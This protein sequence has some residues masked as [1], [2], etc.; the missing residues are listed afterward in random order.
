MKVFYP[1]QH[2]NISHIA[3]PGYRYER[4][5]EKVWFS[6]TQ[7][8]SLQ[9]IDGSKIGIIHLGKKNWNEG[10]DAKGA[11]ILVNGRIMEGDVEFHLKAEDWFHHGHHENSNYKNVILHVLGEDSREAS[12]LP[13]LTIVLDEK[14]PFLD[15]CTLTDAVENPEEI[16]K[17]FA[18]FRWSGLVDSFYRKRQTGKH[19]KQIL[20]KHGFS[21]LGKGGNETIF[22]TLA[23]RIQISD[24]GD[25]DE[26]EFSQLPW[27][28]LGMRPSQRPFSRMKLA[29][30]F[31]GFISGWNENYHF[32]TVLFQRDVE[33]KLTG[34]FGKGICTELILNVLYPGMASESAASGRLESMR[35]WE[36]KWMALT[37]PY[38]YSRY[39]RR[40]S[41]VVS[42]KQ[43]RSVPVLQGLK[44]MDLEFC[45]PRHCTVCPLKKHGSLDTN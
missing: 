2:F 10:P 18:K 7:G 34:R 37:L 32:N 5:L 40:F 1:L 30:E 19:W 17:Q 12:S 11:R 15:E 42:P 43:L 44:Q 27:K 6:L 38:S 29:K 28:V 9:S 14:L 20:M 24:D 36:R 26:R 3:E 4:D 25:F 39:Q 16:L 45:K 8:I 31:A 13:G 33:E 23:D 35:Y 21:I 22:S 41:H